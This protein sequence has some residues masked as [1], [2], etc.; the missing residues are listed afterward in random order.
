MDVKDYYLWLQRPFCAAGAVQANAL[1][2]TIICG[3]IIAHLVAVATAFILCSAVSA[4]L[5]LRRF[6]ERRPFKKNNY[7]G[8]KKNKTK[9]KHSDSNE[10]LKLSPNGAQSIT[11]QMQFLANHNMSKTH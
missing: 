6:L 4:A 5:C 10:T 11:P 3:E 8:V 2:H 7:E 1:V 9:R